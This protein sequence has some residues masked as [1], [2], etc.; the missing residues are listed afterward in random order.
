M[1]ADRAHPTPSGR[2]QQ[3]IRARAPEGDPGDPEVEIGGGGFK[4]AANNQ[5]QRTKSTFVP[6]R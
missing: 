2:R 5:H 3:A 4:G 1:P 6:A